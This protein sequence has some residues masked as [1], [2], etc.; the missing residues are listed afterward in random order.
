MGRAAEVFVRAIA[1]QHQ[2]VLVCRQI[3]D[4]AVAEA[5]ADRVV[6]IEIAQQGQAVTGRQLQVQIAV[7]LQHAQHVGRYAIAEL[8]PGPL[9]VVVGRNAVLAAADAEQAGIDLGTA[10]EQVVAC[11][12]F[13]GIV[14]RSAIQTVIAT[15]TFDAVIALAALQDLGT[16]V[17]AQVVVQPAAFGVGGFCQGADL[18]GHLQ[19]GFRRDLA[20]IGEGQRD[21]WRL[22]VQEALQQQAVLTAGKAQLHTGGAGDQAELQVSHL[23]AFGELQDQGAILAEPSQGV[24]TEA[25]GK[26]EGIL[27][28]AGEQVV[29]AGSAHQRIVAGCALQMIIAFAAK[30]QVV[31]LTTSQL[32]I[33]GQ[34]VD[35]QILDQVVAI[36]VVTL[37]RT[38][39]A[40]GQLVQSVARP[41]GAIGELQM[42]K[43]AAGVAEVLQGQAVAAVTQNQLQALV[44]AFQL[45]RGGQHVGTEA[46]GLCLPAQIARQGVVAAAVAEQDQV[47]AGAVE[48]IVASSAIQQVAAVATIE[49]VI[50]GFAHQA[51]VTGATL[52]VVIAIAT[53]SAFIGEVA[54]E[55][56][57]PGRTLCHHRPASQ[58]AGIEL[59]TI[60]ELQH[61]MA[62]QTGLAV[63]VKEAFQRD[64]VIGAGQLDIKVLAVAAAQL[65]HVC[66]DAGTQDQQIAVGSAAVATEGVV[67]IAEAEQEAVVASASHQVVVTRAADKQVMPA[68]AIQAVIALVAIQAVITCAA[69]QIVVAG[70]AGL[71]VI[72]QAGTGLVVAGSQADAV[73]HDGNVGIVIAIA[74]GADQRLLRQGR[75][76]PE[77]T[78]GENQL[79]VV[80]VAAALRQI[81]VERQAVTA[82]ELQAQVARIEWMDA[83]HAVG[84]ECQLHLIAGSVVGEQR[85]I[86]AA[87]TEQIGITVAAT[88]QAVIAGSAIESVV[89]GAAIQTVVA[90]VALQQVIAGHGLKVII[91]GAADHQIGTLG[92]AHPAAVCGHALADQLLL[93]I[94]DAP[95]GAISELDLQMA[96]VGVV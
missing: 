87:G 78:I 83:L 9:A 47:V 92:A 94:R 17:A 59:A 55:V 35:L 91:P 38:L 33:A 3:K 30:D 85:V 23:Q 96:L 89:A 25:G 66:R 46:D 90:I 82:A 31:T 7:E 64:T 5:Q 6:T 29:I 13:Q 24:L 50:A 34:S 73:I 56:I 76:G 69:V 27:A 80:V 81:V 74:A 58:F 4:A 93:D 48:Q 67:A 77:R 72:T 68:L 54:V 65:Q 15:G 8:H 36:E 18:N 84:Q 95:A 49:I 75:R 11:A 32:I 26:K 61:Q 22:V 1:V 62:C 16:F 45:D 14:T 10:V 2:A 79:Q 28:A 70:L 12:T 20:A 41:E 40:G 86:A 19:Q 52:Q 43:G 21:L 60:I 53:G 51:V 71:Q 44:D 37:G 88:S 39:D 63:D 42:Q 57:I